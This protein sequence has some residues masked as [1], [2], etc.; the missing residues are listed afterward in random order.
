MPYKIEGY[1]FD[2]SNVVVVKESDWS[3]ESTSSGNVH[4]GFGIPNLT[5]DKKVVIARNTLGF[6][7][8]YGGVYP[9]YYDTGTSG[10]PE[11]PAYDP[12]ADCYTER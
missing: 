10:D 12:P 5:N 9:I 2:E 1:S 7:D 6:I 11:D 3:L 8:A 4:Y